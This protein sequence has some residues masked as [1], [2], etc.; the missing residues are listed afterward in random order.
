MVTGERIAHLGRLLLVDAAG[1]QAIGSIAQAGSGTLEIDAAK[2]EK[3][4]GIA[5]WLEPTAYLT[6]DWGAATHIRN[7]AADNI[8]TGTLVVGG[9]IST[10]PRISVKDGSD[11]EIVT[12]GQPS[13]C[14]ATLALTAPFIR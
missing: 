12:I 10:N 7:L 2:L 8:V 9:S 11:V 5:S 4:D 13:G 3:E 6:A 14:G 1:A